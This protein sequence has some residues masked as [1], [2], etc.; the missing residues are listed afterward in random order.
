M[1]LI[2]V[3]FD[4]KSIIFSKFWPGA[5]SQNFRKKPWKLTEKNKNKI[6]FFKYFALIWQLIII[7][8]EYQLSNNE[9]NVLKEPIARWF[10][11]SISWPEIEVNVRLF[12]ALAVIWQSPDV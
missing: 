4:V 8:T 2:S 5:F 1:S 3:N 7:K 9:M 6:L 11:E 10:H 12:N